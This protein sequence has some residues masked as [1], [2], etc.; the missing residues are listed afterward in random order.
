MSR[1]P[2]CNT[3]TERKILDLKDYF[4]TNENFQILECPHCCLLF[5]D[6]RP[7]AH[8][9][10]RYYQSEKYYSHQEK[11]NGLVPRLYS[12][13]KSINLKTKYREATKGIKCGKI[14]DIGCG[15]G[16]FLFKA[17]QKGW[18]VTGIEPE[19]KARKIAEAK[20][21]KT[22]LK[23][24]DIQN[25]PD[26]SFDLITMWHVLEHVDDLQAEITQLQRLLKTNGRLVVA[27][28]NFESYDADYYKD[29]WAAWD[30]PRHLN[31]FCIRSMKDIFQE[32]GFCLSQVKGQKWDAFY[33]SFLSEK[34]KRNKGPLFKAFFRGLISNLKARRTGAYSSLIYVFCKS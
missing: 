1:C 8:V 3:N 19:D 17:K 12:I 28:P 10:G 29:K 21:K 23:P 24:S 15:I 2:W 27:V 11:I 18:S 14:L 9:I 16:D 6:P 32:K 34:Y 26:A 7:D 4:L 5:T 30:V 20:L 33:I 22:V 31:H 25:L 13:V